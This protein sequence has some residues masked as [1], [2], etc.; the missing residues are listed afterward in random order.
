MPDHNCFFCRRPA[1][2]LGLFG[3][4]GGMSCTPVLT[5]VPAWESC[6]LLDRAANEPRDLLEE[7]L[8][9]RTSSGRVAP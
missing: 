5:P 3:R 6:T 1:S 4:D 2:T 8:C 7:K 9:A